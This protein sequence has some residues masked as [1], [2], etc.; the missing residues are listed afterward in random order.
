MSFDTPQKRSLLRNTSNRE[1]H[2]RILDYMQLIIAQF[3]A[4]ISMLSLSS[5][6]I[7]KNIHLLQFHY[8]YPNGYPRPD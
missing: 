3:R 7:H 5:R 6:S 8:N 1:I 2:F 4:N